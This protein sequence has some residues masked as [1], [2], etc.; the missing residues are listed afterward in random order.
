MKRFS[1]QRDDLKQT[2][3]DNTVVVI[4]KHVKKFL[5]RSSCRRNIN[6]FL[7]KEMIPSN[8]PKSM[9]VTGIEKSV[10]NCFTDLKVME[11]TTR[12]HKF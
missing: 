2:S 12:P 7:S 1:K 8:H 11:V 9:V 4:E 6:F 3:Q 10:K 5:M